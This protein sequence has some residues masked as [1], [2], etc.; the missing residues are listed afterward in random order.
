MKADDGTIQYNGGY[1]F[2]LEIDNHMSHDE[3]RLR[4]CALLNM[5]PKLVKFEFT[6]NLIHLCLSFYVELHFRNSI[7]FPFLYI[8]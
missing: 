5:R 6:I 3:F 1:T 2:S 4:I 8:R 7:F